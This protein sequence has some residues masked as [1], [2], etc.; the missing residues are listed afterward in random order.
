MTQS[1]S[2][3]VAVI[4]VDLSHT[5]NHLAQS[6]HAKPDSD[7]M[8]KQALFNIVPRDARYTHWI[9]LR[10]NKKI[11]MVFMILDK[12]T[13]EERRGF[14]VYFSPDVRD[15]CLVGATTITHENAL[16]RALEERKQQRAVLPRAW[17]FQRK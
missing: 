2:R 3:T 16:R 8:Q 5:F 17:H 14:A 11:Q 1:R 4:T 7:F 15:V 9:Y 10:D 12:M 6:W 13:V